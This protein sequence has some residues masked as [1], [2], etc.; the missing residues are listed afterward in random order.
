MSLW[1]ALCVCV[2]VCVCIACRAVTTQTSSWGNW[3]PG[4]ITECSA[5][6]LFLWATFM[7]I[8][9]TNGSKRRSVR[10]GLLEGSHNSAV[11]PGGQ[12][13]RV[14]AAQ[15][16]GVYIWKQIPQ[17]I[18]GNWAEVE[19]SGGDSVVNE[20]P[21]QPLSRPWGSR[22]APHHSWQVGNVRC[23]NVLDAHLGRRRGGHFLCRQSSGGG[24]LIHRH[25]PPTGP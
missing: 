18:P 6:L 22:E 19:G 5:T 13:V 21:S 15:A 2:C 7:I 16:T 14:Q 10:L 25:A 11:Q 9:F 8:I 12:R 23:N 24:E 4:L 3:C 20:V 17:A 1:N